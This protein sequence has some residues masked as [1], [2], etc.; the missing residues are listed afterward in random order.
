MDECA[1]LGNLDG[2]SDDLPFYQLNDRDFNFVAGSRLPDPAH[3][4]VDL[5]DLIINPDKFD[6]CDPDR[7]FQKAGSGALSTLNCNIRSLSKT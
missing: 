7:I 1:N 6:K 4:N 5:F 3:M 2:L